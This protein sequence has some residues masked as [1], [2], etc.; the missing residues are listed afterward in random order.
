MKK[1]FI[2]LGIVISCVSLYAFDAYKKTNNDAVPVECDICCI[3]E[4]LVGW[5]YYT[6]CKLYYK[7][8]GEWLYYGT[9]PVYFNHSDNNDGCNQW[10]RFSETGFSPAEYHGNKRIKWSR[11]VQWQGVYFYF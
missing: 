1:F 7:K 10:V 3:D 2:S 4:E 6:K 8:N 5:T 11:R 9:Y